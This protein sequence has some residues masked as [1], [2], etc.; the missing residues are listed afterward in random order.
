MLV[1]DASATLQACLSADGFRPLR[2]QALVAPPL[3]WSEATSVLHEMLWRRE[4]SSE[5]AAAARRRLQQAPIK[6]R[7]PAALLDAAWRIAEGF[8]WAKTYDAE[9]VALAEILS[10]R[11]FTIDERLKSTASR[12]VEVL[13]PLD[14]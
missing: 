12:I 3:V 8:G 10:C 4:V 13:G 1:I 5:L 7:S 11:L 14:L 6:R 9:Y 2:R